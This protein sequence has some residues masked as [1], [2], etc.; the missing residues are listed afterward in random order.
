VSKND[1]L[2]WCNMVA[3]MLLF[4]LTFSMLMFSRGMMYN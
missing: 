4:V 1:G 2:G 3:K